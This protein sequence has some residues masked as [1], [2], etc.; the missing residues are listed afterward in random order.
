MAFGKWHINTQDIP[1][2]SPILQVTP[3][4]ILVQVYY[5]QQPG[6]LINSEFTVQNKNKDILNQL[7]TNHH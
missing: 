5:N 6:F 3:V 2:K 4:K 7:N 1:K